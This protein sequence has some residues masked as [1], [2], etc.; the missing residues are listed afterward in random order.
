[1]Y[2]SGES[3]PLKLS[4]C[5]CI[6]VPGSFLQLF[7]YVYVLKLCQCFS[8]PKP[9]F[10]HWSK[11]TYLAHLLDCVFWLALLSMD[12]MRARGR[13]NREKDRQTDKHTERE[14]ESERELGK[15]YTLTQRGGKGIPW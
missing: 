11:R 1:M 9:L 5:F 13:E 6:V 2:F 4:I 10:W 3:C 14:S 15:A 8:L 12:G 7:Y